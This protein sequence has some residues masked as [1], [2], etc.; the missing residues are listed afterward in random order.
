MATSGKSGPTSID[1]RSFMRGAGLL[2][3]SSAF[4]Y[5][6]IGCSK[7]VL[8]I[9]CLGPAAAPDPVPGTTYIW[10]SKIGC[11]LDCDLRT[12]HNKYTGGKSTD[13]GPRINAAMAGATADNP[14]TLIIDGSAM[15][16]GLFLPAGGHWSIAGLG[17]GTGFFIKSGTNND[18]IHNGAPD[19]SIP[20]NPGPPA[21]PRGM[22]VSLRNFTVNGNQGNGSNGDSTS[23]MRQGSKY[24]WFCG[25][26]L[27]NLDNVVLENVVVVNTAAFHIRLSNVGNVTA[28]GCVMRSVGLSTDGL[29]FDGPANDITISNCDFATGD[30]SI[31]LNCPEGYSGDISRVAVSNCKFNSLSLMRLYTTDG[32]SLRYTIDTVSVSNCTGT[33]SESAFLIGLI[34]GSKPNSVASLTVTDCNLTSFAVLAIAENFGTIALTNVTFTPADSGVIWT[35]PQANKTCAFVRPSPL[36]GTVPFVGDS[37]SFNNC[38][39]YRDSDRTVLGLSLQNDSVIKELAFNG[40]AVQ[41]NGLY[42]PIPELIEIGA[43]SIG[44]LVLNSLNSNSISAPVSRGGFADMGIVSG[45]GV[46]ATDWGFPDA[47]MANG[48]P[49]ISANSGLPSIKVNGLVEPYG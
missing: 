38:T 44:Q 10:A 21:P 16:S 43:G 34:A 35:P 14:V 8:S 13:D 37:L 32:A 6:L 46:L 19:A 40:F 3:A 15:I 26:S 41:E 17:C 25:I 7:Y 28:T 29:H 20:F 4:G 36:Y 12:G 24:A 47:V 39:V 45:T 30:D 42:D 23:G 1:R 33:F 22:N 5:S 11:A 18:G 27:V 31:A 49:Y 2:A 48:V 9:P